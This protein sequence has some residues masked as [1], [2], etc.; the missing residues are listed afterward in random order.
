MRRS[1]R[2]SRDAVAAEKADA[3]QVR[4]CVQAAFPPL[5]HRRAPALLAD[6]RCDVTATTAQSAP[7][8]SACQQ[9]S[10]G[11][12]QPSTEDLGSGSGVRLLCGVGSRV[13]GSP[14]SDPC[15]LRPHLQ[16]F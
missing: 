7:P 11:L 4:P 14:C 13:S 6:G 12:T 9:G 10:G 8:A 3:V 16:S 15:K 1:R 2:P 5:A